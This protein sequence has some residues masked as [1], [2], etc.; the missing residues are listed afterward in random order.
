MVDK[1]FPPPPLTPPL[2]L[3]L[4]LVLLPPLVL[5]VELAEADDELLLL[6]CGQLFPDDLM[7]G[8]DSVLPDLSYLD[9]KGDRIVGCITTHG[10]EDHIGALPYLIKDIKVPVFGTP[11]TLGLVRHKLEELDLISSYLIPSI[12]SSVISIGYK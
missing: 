9:D 6:D 3:L 7:P 11:F 1:G 8:A 2:A 10:H 12:T 4:L 5:T